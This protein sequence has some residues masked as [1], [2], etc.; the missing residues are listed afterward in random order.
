MIRTMLFLKLI[1]AGHS[2][3]YVTRTEGWFWQRPY[4]SPLL[5]GATFGTEILG[6]LIAVYGVLITPIGWTYA[7]AMW[8]YA[9]VWF[10]VNDAIKLA[11]YR[12]LRTRAGGRGCTRASCRRGMRRDSGGKENGMTDKAAKAAVRPGQE[13]S[14]PWFWP[15]AAGIEMQAAGL[16]LFEKN[17]KFAAGPRRSTRRRRLNGR[18]PNTVLLDWTRC[19][20]ATFPA[21]TRTA[22]R[23][24]CWSTRPMPATAR[25]SP[26]TT[27]P[28]PGR[29]AAC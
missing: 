29:D 6:T 8:A 21:E 16:Q 11:V 13:H 12:G 1:V 5:L 27:G 14:V 3:L 28:E 7:L 20:C 2:T 18:A 4:P 10:L 25:P 19:G 17:M 22:M 24:P 15:L 26:T 23:F 9:L